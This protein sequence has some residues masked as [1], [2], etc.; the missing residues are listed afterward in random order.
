MNKV[1]VLLVEDDMAVRLHINSV[2]SKNFCEVTMASDGEEAIGKYLSQ[3]VQFDV[4]ITDIMMPK[5]NGLELLQYARKEG[6]ADTKMIGM[7]S[8]F[9]S[10]LG[11]LTTEK[12]DLLLTKPVDFEYL[13]K[14]IQQV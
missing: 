14:E 11:S 3:K 7:T 10:Y 4:I 12:F 13:L 2:L 8:G 1:K 9:S 6:Y 5:L